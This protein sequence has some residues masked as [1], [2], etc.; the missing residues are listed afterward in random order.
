M[1]GLST[2]CRRTRPWIPT[3]KLEEKWIPPV[4]E[5]LKLNFDASFLKST[6]EVGCGLILHNY[7]CVFDGV[8]K[9]QAEALAG[10]EATKWIKSKHLW[11]VFGGDCGNVVEV[12]NVSF[13]SVSWTT[14]ISVIG[15]VPMLKG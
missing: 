3:Y 14:N 2:S 13:T 1:I 7:A 10:L 9:E 11:F 4:K 12:I 15:N 6:D 5:Q 8:D